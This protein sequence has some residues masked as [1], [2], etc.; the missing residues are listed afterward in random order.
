MELKTPGHTIKD[1]TVKQYDVQDCALTRFRLDCSGSGILMRLNSI[2]VKQKRAATA[3]TV[4]GFSCGNVVI[5]FWL[6]QTK[7]IKEHV[8]Q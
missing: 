3:I 4:V 6:F 1:Q 5:L 2:P 7:L 8:K